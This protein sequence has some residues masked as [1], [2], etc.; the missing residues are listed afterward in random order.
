[1]GGGIVP[2]NRRAFP[3]WERTATDIHAAEGPTD[4]LERARFWCDVRVENLT[5]TFVEKHAIKKP[6]DPKARRQVCLIK[7]GSAYLALVPLFWKL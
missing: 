3:L 2:G 5:T 6:A 4:Y 1:M 7:R